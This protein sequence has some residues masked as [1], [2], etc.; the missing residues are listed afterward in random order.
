MFES[1]DAATCVR[2]GGLG[3]PPDVDSTAADTWSKVDWDSKRW[4]D[5]GVSMFISSQVAPAV[6]TA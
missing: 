4:G 3:T 2:V 6:F 5:D 1:L